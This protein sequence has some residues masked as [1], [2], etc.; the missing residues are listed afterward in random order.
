VESQIGVFCRRMN[1]KKR[2]PVIVLNWNGIEDTEKC[3]EHL[4][5]QTYQHLILYLAD[6]GSDEANV[7]RLHALKSTYPDI[8][9]RLFSENLGFTKAHNVI[10]DEI[11]SS[12]TL[13]PYI[14]LLNNDAFAEPSWA[15]EL[16]QTGIAQDAH[17][18]S[19][20][21][22]NYFI[23]EVLDN[24]GHRFLNTGE[25]IPSG[26]GESVDAYLSVER[27]IG[28][29]AG[30]ALYET[31]M[32]R[33]IGLF[34]EYFNTGY[35][36]AELGARASV[37]GYTSVYA[38]RAVVRHKV[39]TSVA[40]IRDFDYV[41]KTQLNIFY[42]YFKLM[43]WPIIVINVPW[44]IFKYSMVLIL[45]LIFGRL[46]FFKVMRAA[47]WRALTSERIR[48]KN[49]RTIFYKNH[50]PV[51][52]W[53]IILKMEFFLWFDIKRFF[54]HMIRGEKTQFEKVHH[55]SNRE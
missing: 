2:I 13:P 23:P 9:L 12:S 27:N 28:P 53:K 7:A 54:K 26:S 35:E 18:V 31:G 55:S 22:V 46:F 40:K 1:E 48:I 4:M 50:Q 10:M 52:S 19:S 42:T 34:D 21:M 25:I 15:S 14:L 8:R 39:S 16:I 20:R 37:L 41:L 17:M 44:M 6:N 43:P 24:I 49:A 32:L 30:A 3:I 38:P 51:S 45:N 29:C 47:I 36:D 5:N 33:S 11:L